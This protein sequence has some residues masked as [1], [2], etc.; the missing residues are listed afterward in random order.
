MTAGCVRL[1]S[2]ACPQP[3]GFILF[4][5]FFFGPEFSHHQPPREYHLH[6]QQSSSP[7]PVSPLRD[8]FYFRHPTF[9]FYLS[10]FPSPL[11]PS[12]P[13]PP[14]LPPFSRQQRKKCYGRTITGRSI[15]PQE[16]KK[17]PS[18]L[19]LG[20]DIVSQSFGFCPLLTET[21]RRGTRKSK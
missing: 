4:F 21:T 2:F 17:G 9:R 12:P 15:P 11:P 8:C 3:F 20:F 16:V 13:P 7:P 19:T 5:C 10:P 1:S 14:Y 6:L 18:P